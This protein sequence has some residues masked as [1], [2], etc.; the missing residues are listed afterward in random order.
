MFF[1][2]FLYLRFY[3]SVAKVRN[4]N[5]LF[6]SFCFQSNFLLSHIKE[7]SSIALI[8]TLT[9]CVSGLVVTF[10]KHQYVKSLLNIDQVGSGSVR[11]AIIIPEHYGVPVFPHCQRR[12][13][14]LLNTHPSALP[15]PLNGL[16]TESWVLNWN[17][18]IIDFSRWGKLPRE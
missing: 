8:L 11:G 18:D 10:Q 15:C 17:K 5:L 12:T 13:L 16:H 2:G 9:S 1:W 14:C 3:F 4:S 6:N 7:F